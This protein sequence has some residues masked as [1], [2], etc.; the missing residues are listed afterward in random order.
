MSTEPKGV[1]LRELD[2][3]RADSRKVGRLAAAGFRE[4]R[5]ITAG[6]KRFEMMKSHTLDRTQPIG[7]FLRAVFIVTTLLGSATSFAG[8]GLSGGGEG[9]V[10]RSA[11][12]AML[13]A[14]LLDL[15]EGEQFFLTHLQ[16]EPA[17]RP[18]LEIAK[19]YAAQ[20]DQ[21]T[22]SINPTSQWTNSTN[23]RVTSTGVQVNPG[24]LMDHH[25]QPTAFSSL[26][27]QID[28]EKM[29][30]PGTDFKIADLGD[31]NPRIKPS[32]SGCSIEQI[33]IYM[34]GSQEVHVVSAVW[35]HLNNTN[36]AALL[37]HE[38]LYRT[39]RVLGDTNSDR[40]R[41]TVAY[42]FGGMK[43][44]WLLDS[45]PNKFLVC[46]SDDSPS[47]FQFI[48]V[49]GNNTLVKAYFLVYNREVMLTKTEA[50]LELAPFAKALEIETSSVGDQTTF[51]V[52]SNPLVDLPTYNFSVSTDDSTGKV[53]GAIEAVALSGGLHEKTISCNRHVTEVLYGPNGSVQV[54]S[55]QTGSN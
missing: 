50:Y 43:F 17:N 11:G 12:G 30:M 42:L 37:I 20:L 53:T 15:V 29:L 9:V 46:W 27:A 35:D 21:A 32:K 14:R 48:V 51:R 28:H 22:P 18:Y 54:G 26:V 34:D 3:C 10:C 2:F 19:L 25:N 55:V 33:A 7:Q 36:K 4:Q 5:Q 8:P 41:K 38:A 49:P 1:I 31:S 52:L 45:V 39:L 24:F 6:L 47:S 16:P 40:T 44:T 13:S 23:G